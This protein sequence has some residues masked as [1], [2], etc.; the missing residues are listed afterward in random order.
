[1]DLLLILQPPIS[2]LLQ[3]AFTNTVFDNLSNG[4]LRQIIL[5]GAIA[6]VFTAS[7][8]PAGPDAPLL[9][10]SG[11]S[12]FITSNSSGICVNGTPLATENVVAS[13][14]I[15][16]VVGK[17]L[18]PPIG[19]LLQTVQADTSFSYFAAAV[20]RASTGSTNISSMLSGG[21]VY[22]IFLPDNGAFQNAGYATINDIN[23]ANPDSLSSVLEY[24]IIPQRAFTSDF[25]SGKM[26][27][28]L[29]TGKSITLTMLSGAVYGV[30]GSGNSGKIVIYNSNI[31]ARSG[32]IH[33]I[34]QLLLP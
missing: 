1:M 25:V 10:Q 30:Q 32:V 29:L 11:D 18:L 4:S 22:T 2:S 21:N 20:A 17:A 31:V 3:Q 16:H 34:G 23:N 19:N 24:H 9:T 8:F 13:N 33:V 7:Q 28:T 14:G 27:P 26:V 15:M 6:Q 12:I 5:Y